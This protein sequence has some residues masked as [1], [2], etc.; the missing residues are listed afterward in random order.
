VTDVG[1]WDFAP[2]GYPPGAVSYTGPTLFP[3]GLD[4]G[5]T[6]TGMI[7][8]GPGGAVANFPAVATGLPGLSPVVNFSQVQLA[9]NATL[10]TPNPVVT[11]T[12]PGTNGTRAVY[13][14]VFYVNAGQPGPAASLFIGLAEDLVGA[15]S[16]GE[17]I[18]FDAVDSVF[19]PQAPK[20][21]P[22]YSITTIP[23]TASTT[24]AQRTLTSINIP[25]QPW[26]WTPRVEAQAVITNAID[27]RVDL[28]AYKGVAGGDVVGRALG[29]GGGAGSTTSTLISAFG[30]DMPG[31]TQYGQTPANASQVILL[32]AENQTASNN[33]WSTGAATFTVHVD[34]LP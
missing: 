6:K 25:A 23:A 12:D 4:A 22:T 27:T 33:P 26:P 28:V 1:V 7:V 14:V 21:G 13:N 30:S 10:P 11:L 15:I 3:A 17:T 9:W 31:T 32:R 5:T 8:F 20:V 24:T 19:R 34:P 2:A 29:A 18:I 16:A